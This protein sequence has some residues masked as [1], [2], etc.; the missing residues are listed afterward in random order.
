M[1][2]NDIDP[3][4]VEYLTLHYSFPLQPKSAKSAQEIF[5]KVAERQELRKQQLRNYCREH[6]QE[7]PPW[8]EKK[9]LKQFLNDD[10]DKYIYC[11]VPKVASTP[12]RM[13]LLRVRNDSKLKITETSAHLPKYWSLLSQYNTEEVS[14]RLASYFKFLFVREPFHRLLSAYRDKFFGKNGIYTN[15]FRRLIVKTFRPHEVEVAGKESNNVTFTEFLTFILNYSNALTR[16][17]HWRQIEQLC[18]PCAFEYDFIGH[19]ETLEEDAAYLLNTAR[20]DDR[21]TFPTVRASRASSDFM[22]YYSQ[23]PREIIF[24]LGEAFR[25]DFEMFGYSFPGPLKSLLGNYTNAIGQQR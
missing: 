15:G 4:L 1:K 22:T 6:V 10:S 7:N 20:L 2:T 13:T 18:F 12:M 25:G 9:Q 14:E 19:F 23:V 8:V 3:S 16:D 5:A 17:G 11:A 21:V 24:R